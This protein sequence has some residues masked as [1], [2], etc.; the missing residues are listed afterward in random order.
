MKYN[1]ILKAATIALIFVL[2]FGFT[3]NA[4]TTPS[5]NK[6]K[7]S[8]EPKFDLSGMS[9]EELVE[10]KDQIN[11]AI[12]ES[13]E[14]EEVTVPQGTWIV[15]EDIP[16]G[17]WTVKCA[18]VDRKA[19]NLSHCSVSWGYLDDNGEMEKG[20]GSYHGYALINNPNSEKYKSGANTEETIEL[21]EGM[22]VVIDSYFAPAVFSPYSGKQ[23]LGF[24]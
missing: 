7:E 13:E 2:L 9:Y 6:T 15:G 12:W 18:D 22:A 10:L 4:K 20:S 23:S 16:V 11:L 14:W 17:H 5:S 24:K 19:A 1:N 3:V 8:E 21:K